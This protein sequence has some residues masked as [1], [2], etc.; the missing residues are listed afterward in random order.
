[1]F[2]CQITFTEVFLCYN[3][4]FLNNFKFKVGFV[5]GH[6][7]AKKLYSAWYPKVFHGSLLITASKM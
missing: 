4:A 1:M 6:I 5:W 2:K 7:E 3:V